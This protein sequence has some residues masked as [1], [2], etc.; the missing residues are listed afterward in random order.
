MK[1]ESRRFAEFGLPGV[2]DLMRAQW[3]A[4][5]LMPPLRGGG[6][7]S[8]EVANGT[9]LEGMHFT[10]LK[11][12]DKEVRRHSEGDRDEGIQMRNAHRV[13]L[14]TPEGGLPVRGPLA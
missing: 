8:R 5:A 1:Q 6:R 13:D 12:K 7:A 3:A 2:A 10:A 4:S 11:E 9:R 14:R